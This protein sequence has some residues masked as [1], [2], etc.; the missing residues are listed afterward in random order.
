MHFNYDNEPQEYIKDKKEETMEDFL[1]TLEKSDIEFLKKSLVNFNL[2]ESLS[3]K[4]NVKNKRNNLISNRRLQ[5]NMLMIL[6]M[7]N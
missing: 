4:Y 6:K 2:K 1:G 5:Q 3:R 7:M